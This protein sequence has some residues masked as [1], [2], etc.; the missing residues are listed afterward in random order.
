MSFRH[1][2]SLAAL[3]AAAAAPAF[4]QTD[5]DKVQIKATSL[6]EGVHMLEGAGGNIGVSVGEDGVILIDD[7]YAPLSDKILFAVRQISE[8][9]I[10]F[11]LNTHFH[12]D[13]TGGNETFGKGGAWIVAHDN[14]RTRMSADQF[15]RLW[16]RTVPASPAGTWPVVTFSDNLSFH[17][18]GQDIHVFHVENAHTDGDVIVHFQNRNVIHMGD[19]FFN[20]RYPLIDVGAG[21]SIRGMIRAANAALLLADGGTKIIPGHGAVGGREDLRAFRDMLVE[22]EKRIQALVVAGQTADQ[23]AQAKPLADFDATWGGGFMTPERFL[24]VVVDDLTR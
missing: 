9:P 1:A 20:G 10:R 4:A 24:Q 13:H 19:C 11:V 22:A 16:Q 5:F 21:G 17:L 14:V 8:Q 15:H 18:N 3:A 23:I 12:G 7:Q 2:L 6:A